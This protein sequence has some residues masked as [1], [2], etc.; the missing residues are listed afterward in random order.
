MRPWIA[1]LLLAGCAS[2]AP[3][4]GRAPDVELRTLEGKPLP[5]ASLWA[6]KP[7]LLVFMT[8]W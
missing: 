7:V 2:G 4:T 3:A 1:A 6:E 5:A 8:V